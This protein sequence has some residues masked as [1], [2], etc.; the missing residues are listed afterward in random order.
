MLVPVGDKLKE[1][2]FFY[3]M[4]QKTFYNTNLLYNIKSEFIMI[5]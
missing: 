2:K 3:L 4:L 5:Y 1:K